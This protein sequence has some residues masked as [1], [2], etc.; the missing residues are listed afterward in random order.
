MTKSIASLN[1]L[2]VGS[3]LRTMMGAWA[4]AAFLP[5]PVLALTDPARSA[6]LSCL[7]LGLS[8]ALLVTEAHRS[9]EQNGTTYSWSSETAS[10]ITAISVNVAL[11][12]GCL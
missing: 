11:F 3:G 9:W 7:Y 1:F 5:L 6:D 12:G 2:S 10:I 8:N 4:V